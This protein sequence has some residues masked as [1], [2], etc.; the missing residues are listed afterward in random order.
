MDR[1]AAFKSQPW[2]QSLFFVGA[3]L[4]T[5]ILTWKTVDQAGRNQRLE[6]QAEE[7]QARINLLEQQK[8]NQA[9]ENEFFRSEY[10]LDLA[11]R[12][13]QGLLLEDEAVLVI[14]PDKIAQLKQDYQLPA[15]EEPAEEEEL[16]NLEMWWRLVFRP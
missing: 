1:I 8:K 10:Y 6:T 2:K 5:L 4:L 15:A 7:I 12:E 3:L 16:S 9:L 13:Q 14:N 11:V